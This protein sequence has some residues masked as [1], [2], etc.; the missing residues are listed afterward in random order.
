MPDAETI[1]QQQE[2]LHI[3]RQTLAVYIQQLAAMGSAHA[4]PAVHHGIRE[5]RAAIQRIKATL[6]GWGVAV[7]DLPNDSD[8]TAPAGATSAA[9]Q[10]AQQRT[11]I[12]GDIINI[13]NI[14]GSIINVKS[15]MEHMTQA[16]GAL[17][18]DNAAKNELRQLIAQLEAELQKAPASRLA[19]AEAIAEI[20]NDL[21]EKAAK[22]RPNRTLIQISAEAL[23]IGT[24][25]SAQAVLDANSAAPTQCSIPIAPAQAGSGALPERWRCAESAYTAALTLNPNFVR[26]YLGLGNL[27]FYHAEQLAN[28]PQTDSTHIQRC[29]AYISTKARYSLGLTSVKLVQ[30]ACTDDAAPAVE[31]LKAVV[32]VYPHAI[33]WGDRPSTQ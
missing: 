16:I 23:W 4:P 29:D 11:A 13:S 33:S 14:S 28:A 17:P 31:Q 10:S 1:A 15:T 25:L 12:S 20:A 21:V 3:Q 7:D 5:A 27:W 26:P 30:A 8:M 22:E 24:A 19:D 2:L 6:R 32:L 18:G 9:A